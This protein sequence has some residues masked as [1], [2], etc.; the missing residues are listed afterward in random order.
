MKVH[1]KDHDERPEP[2]YTSNEYDIFDK[3]KYTEK[4]VE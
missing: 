4:R 2:V 1:F 3:I